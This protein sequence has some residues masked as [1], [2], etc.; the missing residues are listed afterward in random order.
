MASLRVISVTGGK[1]GVGKTHLVANLGVLA[2]QRRL[3]TVIIDADVGL[4]S[5]HVLFGLTP[6]LH[7]GDVLDGAELDEALMSTP[8]GVALLPAASG[9]RSLTYLSD[10]QR[11]LMRAVWEQL[12][13]RF[14][15]VLIDCPPGIG[16]DALFSASAAD[17]V[18]LL[19]T[20]E[21]TSLL[22][23]AT[24]AHAL[25]HHTAIR[26]IDVVINGARSD[27][28][29]QLAFGK[30]QACSA[31]APTPKLS[32]LGSLPDDHNIRRAAALSQPLVTLASASP[33]A[34]AMERLATSLLDGNTPEHLLANSG[35]SLL[36][37]ERRLR[38]ADARRVG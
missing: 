21:P 34:R 24:L 12:A 6:T 19:A 18:L 10:E 16:R 26:T 4:A 35:G 9:E 32:Y 7:V 17:R 20:P 27:R 33:A 22:D 15:V 13:E 38:E 5:A 30:L 31:L 28:Q 2:V 8:Q 25:H 3:R 23:A 29:G 11:Q 36:G 37:F 1:G 14:D